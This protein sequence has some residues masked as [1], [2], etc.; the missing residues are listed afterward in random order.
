MEF[1]EIENIDDLNVE[2]Y[3]TT[4][5][6]NKLIKR[7]EKFYNNISKKN[8]DEKPVLIDL[9]WTKSNFNEIYENYY[10]T[11]TLNERKQ[12]ASKI[13]DFVYKIEE[14]ADRTLP[15]SKGKK[16]AIAIGAAVLIAGAALGIAYAAGAFNTNAS[17]GITPAGPAVNPGST[18]PIGPAVIPTTPTNPDPQ[19]TPTTP[20]NPDPEIEP[21][22][23]S[24]PGT[25]IT[26]P[27]EPTN[28]EINP[29]TGEPTTP[30]VTITEAEYKAM[31]YDELT[32]SIQ[33]YFNEKEPLEQFK[34][35]NVNIEDINYEDGTIYF[36]CVR[37]NKNMFYVVNSDEISNYTTYEDLNNNLP[38]TFTQI[39][40]QTTQE[41]SLA[42][43]IADFALQ[44][45]EV[46]SFLA[47]NGIYSTSNYTVLNAT[48]F[49]STANGRISDIILKFDD[50]IFSMSIGGTTGACP[51]QEAYLQKLK[52]GRLSILDNFEL[53]D[54]SELD[55]ASASESYTFTSSYG[56]V[57]GTM[58]FNNGIGSMQFEEMGM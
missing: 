35:T 34:L 10:Q 37:N 26:N 15:K 58:V 2:L 27:T 32:S 23:P 55:S 50:K 46:I 24:N 22:N 6:F 28:P 29:G 40:R 3:R 36:N 13:Q 9:N 21:S 42:N 31:F 18:T 25:E 5:R 33:T 38:S 43:D 47:Q 57:K 30:E 19:V 45:D 12:L 44:Q 14:Y 17:V 11:E 51:T 7:I 4:K 54:Y 41:Q 1:E 48:E 49:S 56:N 8:N 52:D 16:I 20:T 39:A 53:L